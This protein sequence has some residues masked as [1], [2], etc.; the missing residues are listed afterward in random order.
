M[1]EEMDQED[2]AEVVQ[3]LSVG[4]LAD[5]LD[6]MEPDMTADLLGEFSDEQT[7]ALLEEM[8][9]SDDV[10][11]LLAKQTLGLHRHF[12]WFNSHLLIALQYVLKLLRHTGLH[13]AGMAGFLCQ[14]G[15]QR[16]DRFPLSH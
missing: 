1:L 10:A 14:R 11:P 5:I 4:E 7:A 8:E 6:E 3:N 2:M 13:R 12:V 9:E 15:L 16:R